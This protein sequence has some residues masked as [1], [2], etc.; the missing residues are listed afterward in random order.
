MATTHAAGDKG[1]QV[2]GGSQEGQGT[3]KASET[4]SKENYCE[5]LCQ[6]GGNGHRWRPERQK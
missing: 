3:K 1:R 4:E 6:V 5:A 2:L